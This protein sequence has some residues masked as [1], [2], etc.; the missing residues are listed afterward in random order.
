MM[1]F[2]L[3]TESSKLLSRNIPT[4]Q[5]HSCPVHIVTIYGHEAIIQSNNIS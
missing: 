2:I 5:E 3:K 4:G 1:N